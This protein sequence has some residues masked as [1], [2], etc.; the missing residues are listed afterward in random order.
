MWL[1]GLKS[2]VDASVEKN[3]V[4]SE[5]VARERSLKESPPAQTAA[6]RGTS[7]FCGSIVTNIHDTSRTYSLV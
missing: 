5:K 6:G 3:S 1:A 7:L 2:V 4:K